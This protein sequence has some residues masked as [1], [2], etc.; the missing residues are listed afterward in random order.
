MQKRDQFYKKAVKFN[1]E[2]K[3]ALYM[4]ETKEFYK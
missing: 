3:W 2:E 4:Q 1:T